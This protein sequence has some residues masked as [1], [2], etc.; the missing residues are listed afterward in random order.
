M[1]KWAKQMVSM[2]LDDEEKYDAPQPIKMANKPDFPYGLQLCLD[3]KQ[4]KKVGLDADCE[5]G[6]VICLRALGRVTSVS[7]H[8][9]GNGPQSRVEI[10][11]ERLGVEPDSEDDK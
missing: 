5:V 10:Q 3:E 4:L 7:N 1:A 2:E 8:D 11:I 9:N 6:D